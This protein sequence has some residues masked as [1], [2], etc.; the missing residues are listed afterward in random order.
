MIFVKNLIIVD[1][2][3]VAEQFLFAL[4]RQHIRSTFPDEPCCANRLVNVVV[5]TEQFA[6]GSCILVVKGLQNLSLHSVAFH[7]RHFYTIVSSPQ[8]CEIVYVHPRKPNESGFE[9]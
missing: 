7:S 4:D 5:R 2:L 3:R 6:W 1:G 8:R 9:H